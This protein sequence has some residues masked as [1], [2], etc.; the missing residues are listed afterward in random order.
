M[1][2]RLRIPTDQYA[3]LEVDFEGTEQEIVEKYREL[4]DLARPQEGLTTNEWNAALDRYLE[5]NTM[6]S[7]VYQAMSDKQKS[8]IQEIKRS[9][10]RIDYKNNKE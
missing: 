9:L 5:E 1:K 10:K 2:A 7:E 3:Y 4:A 8:L 6:N